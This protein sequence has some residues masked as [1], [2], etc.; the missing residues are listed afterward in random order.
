MIQWKKIK[1][2]LF[3]IEKKRERKNCINIKMP[4]K[5]LIKNDRQ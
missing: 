4:N 1:L 3:N 5:Q 2:K